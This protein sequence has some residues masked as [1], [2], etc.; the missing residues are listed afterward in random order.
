MFSLICMMSY[1][2]YMKKLII[3]R[4]LDMM[5]EDDSTKTNAKTSAKTD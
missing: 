2:V 4:I 3:E 5:N 1:D